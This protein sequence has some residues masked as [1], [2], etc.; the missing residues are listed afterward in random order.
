MLLIGRMSYGLVSSVSFFLACIHGNIWNI[1][2]NRG[3]SEWEIGTEQILGIY[4]F[5]IPKFQL[6]MADAEGPG[7]AGRSVNSS[8]RGCGSGGWELDTPLMS[9]TISS[10]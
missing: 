4:R 5:K 6:F 8:H 7:F 2:R 9:L 10:L 3:Y 1:L